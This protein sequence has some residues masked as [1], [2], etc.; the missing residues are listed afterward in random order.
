MIVRE[1]QLSQGRKKRERQKQREAERWKEG[2][3]V[4]R[5]RKEKKKHGEIR[6]LEMIRRLKNNGREGRRSCDG[7]SRKEGLVWVMMGFACHGK[8]LCVNPAGSRKPWTAL[9]PGNDMDDF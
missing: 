8:K 6:K 4:G 9:M 3:Q 7:T 5:E 1:I 2:K